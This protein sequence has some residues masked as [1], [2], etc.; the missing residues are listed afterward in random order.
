MQ[1]SAAA[2]AAGLIA[3]AVLASATLPRGAAAEVRIG[4]ARVTVSTTVG[5]RAVIDRSP[6]RIHFQ[7]ANGAT[8]L[9]QLPGDNAGVGR[10]SASPPLPV[11]RRRAGAADP[12]R[13]VR[14]HG[15]RAPGGP[16]PLRYLAGQPQLGHRRRHRLRRRAVVSSAQRRR[17]GVELVLS[18]C[19]PSGRRLRRR[20]SRP[21][22]RRDAARDRPADDPATASRRCSTAFAAPRRRGVPRLRR[23]PQRARPARQRVLQL[24]RSRR[25][26]ARA[27]PTR[28]T[29]PAPGPAADTCSPTAEAAAYYVQSSFI[30][31]ARLRLPARPRRALALAPG[32]P[33]ARTPG[34]S[35]S[36]A[37]ALDY[38]VAPG[39]APAGD[40][41]R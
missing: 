29:A 8:V 11:R 32:A 10:P 16:V 25:T 41:R 28:L 17:S 2:R 3:L 36:A 22:P 1:R 39:A 19:D 7:K 21:G 12:V 34:R 38:V 27:A 6:L 18:T 33:T 5:A 24:A 37:P 23:A 35:R 30:S 4:D 31:S 14:L 9:A 40:R 26:S 20:A 13:A 15:R